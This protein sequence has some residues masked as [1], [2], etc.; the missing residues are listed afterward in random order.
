MNAFD[1]IYVWHPLGMNA[2][3]LF[4]YDGPPP[5][6]LGLNVCELWAQNVLGGIKLKM[7]LTVMGF[8]FRKKSSLWK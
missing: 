6:A 1:F 2:L 5:Q 3:I 4:M 8:V 7:I